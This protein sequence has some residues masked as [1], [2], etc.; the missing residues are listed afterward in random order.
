MAHIWGKVVNVKVLAFLFTLQWILNVSWNPI[1][2]YYRNITLGFVIISLLTLLIGFF[3][4]RYW[5]QTKLYSFLVA[6]YFMWLIIATS[7]NGYILLK[8]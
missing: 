1:F 8:N 6:P 3:L 4:V 5:P 7:L 2:F